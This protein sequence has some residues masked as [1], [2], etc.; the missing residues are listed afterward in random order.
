MSQSPNSTFAVSSQHVFE[1]SKAHNNL[2]HLQQ[3]HQSR[4]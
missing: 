1:N 2:K 3:S 4:K